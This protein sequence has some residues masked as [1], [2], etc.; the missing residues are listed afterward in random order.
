MGLDA[1]Q[2]VVGAN[3]DIYVAPVDTAAPA[4]AADSWGAGWK[5]LGFATDDGVTITDGKNV[6]DLGV[7]QSFYPAR[8][9]VTAREFRVA[10][11]LRQWEYDTVQFAFGGSI[12]VVSNGQFKFVPPDPEDLDERA[13]G[14]EWRDGS[15]TY[16]LIVPRGLVVE[17][18]ETQLVR[19]DAANLPIT[20]GVLGEANT[21]PWYILT[22]DTAFAASGS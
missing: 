21:D 1:D 22:D 3:G 11:V 4:T 14:V 19:T 17:D 10:F 18:V 8:R 5:N 7:W 12:E 15:K 6:E 9:I 16:R 2:I 13:L 20:F